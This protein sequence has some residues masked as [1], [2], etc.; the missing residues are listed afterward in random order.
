MFA[1][2]DTCR[3]S[4]EDSSVFLFVCLQL[5]PLDT[6]SFDPL[7]LSVGRL[8]FFFSFSF[9]Y[10]LSSDLSRIG[11]RAHIEKNAAEKESD[12]KKARG[13]HALVSPRLCFSTLLSYILAT[14][15]ILFVF[16][17]FSCFCDFVRFVFFF[18]F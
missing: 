1:E 6:S 10:S 5:S 11:A 4:R 3:N 9:Q 15:Y 8:L 2:V 12:R 13:D 16:F 14:Y 17:F 18:S 7:F